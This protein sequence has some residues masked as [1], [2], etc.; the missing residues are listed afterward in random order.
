MLRFALMILLL[1]T[2]PGCMTQAQRAAAAQADVED[3]VKVFGPACEKL[4]YAKDTDTWRECILR[5][6]TQEDLRYRNRPTSTTCVG[7]SGFYN[8]YSY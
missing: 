6:R 5:L 2:L 1:A 7:Q 3:M 8:C 4:G